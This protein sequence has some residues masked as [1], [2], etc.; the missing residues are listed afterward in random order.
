MVNTAP[1]ITKP[2][3]LHSFSLLLPSPSDKVTQSFCPNLQDS[4][5]KEASWDLGPEPPYL[6]GVPSWF[7]WWFRE[8]ILDSAEKNIDMVMIG[9][10]VIFS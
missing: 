9:N 6:F 2:Y 8:G 4:H 3:F 7:P 5:D 1:W 10:F